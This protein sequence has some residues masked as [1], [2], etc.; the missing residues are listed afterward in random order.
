MLS[1][2]VRNS[3]RHSSLRVLKTC[4]KYNP[5]RIPTCHYHLL[6]GTKIAKS[7]REEAFKEIKQIQI[8]SP[9]FEP[10]LKI[11]Q[12]GTRPDSTAYVRM[13]LK[14]S[15][16]SGVKCIVEKLPEDID[17]L[18]LLQKIQ[19]VNDDDSIH[20]L[21]IQLPLPRH[22]NEAEVTNAVSYQK[23]VDGFHRFNVGELSKRGGKPY[24]I[25][26][27]PNGCIR[28]LKES[29]IDLRGKR[30]VVIG[31]SDIVGTPVASLL[32][33]LNATVTICHRYT[34]NIA[35]VV[36]NADV[37]IAACGV[38]NM[39]KPNWL[40]QDAIVID[41]GINYVPDASKKS[42]RKLVGDVDF[43]LCKDKASYIT[44][45]PGGV[46]PMTVAMLVQ[47]V[48]LAAKRQRE[49]STRMPHIK[50][51]P[52]K[53]EAKVPSDI[54]IS[55]KQKPKYIEAVANELGVH[56]SELELY[57]HYKAK[58]SPKI[59]N[60]LADNENGKYVLVA[61]ITP[62]PLGEGKSTT[63]IGL[64]QALS[65]HLHKPSIANVRQPSMGPTFGV[66]GGA[67]GG[68][69]AQ[70]IPMDEFN[71]HLTG[72]IHAIGAA[73]NLLA[74]AIDTRMFHEATQ[75]KH[76]TFYKR[77]VPVKKGVRSFTPSMLTRLNKLGINK[78]NPDDL[79][80]EEII[81]FARLNID[82]DTI[83]I[84]R[85]VD[86]NDRMLRQIT[87][88]QA[89]TEKGFTRQT[90]FDITVASELMAILA[91]SKDLKDLRERVGR[92]VIG[93]NYEKEP[94][95][96]NDIGCAGA[97]AALLKDAVKPN[98][99][100]TLEGTPVLVH[101]GPFANISIGASSVIA[102]RVALKLVGKP[103]EADESAESGYVVTEAGF[104]FTMGGER[105]FNIK[106]RASGLTPNAVVLVATVRA[107]KLHGGAPDVK[108]GQ[109][110]P[111][112]YLKENVD[113]VRN[114]TANMCKQ[115]ENIK[116]FG[117]PV[118]VAINKFESDTEAEIDAIKEAA[119]RVGAFDVV[120]TNHWAEGGKGA[121][122][123]AEAVIE[124]S[125][126]PSEF[127]FLY[128]VN[129]TVENKLST[130][131]QKMYGG[132]NIEI[133]EEAQ[134]KI[135][136]Y[137]Q[138]GFGDLPIC[139]A[140]TQ[141]S[142]SHDAKLKNVPTGFTFPIRDVRASIGAGYLY[143]LAAEI[144]TIPG[145]STHAGYMNVEIDEDGEIEGLF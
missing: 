130:I 8:K 115:I 44:P 65:A 61:G 67:A 87:I 35:D 98:L 103:K 134:K 41:V 25:P 62:T 15:E 72:D 37:V 26:C 123:L 111:E 51:L 94:I 96:V 117:V 139:I 54:E 47:N 43:E 21:L 16:E 131:V 81:K 32:K 73:N 93:S 89:P 128:D 79:N 91:L 76:E 1:V 80:T 42:G 57:G 124:A 71:M 66:K 7:I 138:Q 105:F 2:S 86:V 133:S 39:V 22:L 58:V 4:S 75:K 46:G 110:L 120:S 70:V 136:M 68:G 17:E 53:I 97:I 19:Q 33:D 14:A 28:L 38:P 55:R 18:A 141:Y 40:K 122:K 36:K 63:T 100:Q 95:T 90:G 106:C 50:P 56:P 6:S 29:G 92:I 125:K 126:Q 135:D 142:L 3:L 74:A 137:R 144:Q 82:P 34:E 13:K 10:C 99:M 49:E 27:T 121:I 88:G 78:T 83:T 101:A 107:L 109:S 84:K 127:K 114:G 129:D 5:V 11:I 12:V 69:Y 140:K 113:L 20:G 60:R 104:D 112:E 48:L 145:L 31:R 108:P 118:V 85:V 30:A 116:Q 64:V 9:S 143:A 23:D 45:V 24:F 119:Q 52:L 102:D 77:L 59:A 132:A